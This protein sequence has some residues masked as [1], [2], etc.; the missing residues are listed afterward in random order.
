M[1]QVELREWT[2]DRCISG[3]TGG[4]EQAGSVLL[5]AEWKTSLEQCPFLDAVGRSPFIV[6]RMK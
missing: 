2:P 4:D 1:R 6:K 3:Q 5:K